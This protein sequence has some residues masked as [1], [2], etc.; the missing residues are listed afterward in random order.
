MRADSDHRRR[1]AGPDPAPHRGSPLP[2]VR[3]QGGRV[4]PVA[5]R[6]R[7]GRD[8]AL[9]RLHRPPLRP[10]LDRVTPK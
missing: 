1:L 4:L 6:P 8:E 9:L 5:Q 7:R 2:E 10:P 3:A